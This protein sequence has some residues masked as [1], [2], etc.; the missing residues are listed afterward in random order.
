MTD[1]VLAWAQDC[2]GMNIIVD[3]KMTGS[4]V[5]KTRAPQASGIT[6]VDAFLAAA[7]IDKAALAKAPKVAALPPPSESEEKNVFTVLVCGGGN[8][9]QVATAM[10]AARYNTI[11]IS[12]YADEAAKWKAALGDDSY[13]LTLDTG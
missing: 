6:T 4:D 12:L 7:N 13:E 11:A 3:G 9:A 10:Y 8:A 5:A 1:K 2:I